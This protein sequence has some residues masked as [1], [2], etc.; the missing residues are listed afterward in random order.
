MDLNV[1][2]TDSRNPDFLKLIKLL[3]ADLV[4]RNGELQKQFDKHNQ[5]NSI[6]DVVV[7]Y[8]EN[9]PVACGAYKEYDIH[10]VEIK[11]MYVRKEHRRRG[12]AKLIISKLEELAKDKGY[13]YALLETG[14]KQHEAISLYK[15]IGYT[16]IDNYEP[17]VGNE[18]S[19]C[20]KKAL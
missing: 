7:I 8:Q 20:M 2:R 1:L 11:R 9:V 15:N 14:V 5:V 16:V 13:R 6:Q 17:Y 3:D 10:S 18:N 12:L 19:V 4:E